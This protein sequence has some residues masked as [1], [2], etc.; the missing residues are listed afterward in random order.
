MGKIIKKIFNTKELAPALFL[1]NMFTQKKAATEVAQSIVGKNN[2][3]NKMVKEMIWNNCRYHF[4]FDEYFTYNLDMASAAKKKTFIPVFEQTKWVMSVNRMENKHIFANKQDTYEYFGE[5]FKRDL[6]YLKS[7]SN[8][9]KDL[10]FDFVKKNSRFI[11]KPNDLECGKGIRIIDLSKN[12]FQNMSDCFYDIIS[13]N[14][15]GVVLEEL[16]KQ[17]EKTAVFHPNSV[18][19]VRMITFRLDDR[20]EL[21]PPSFRMGVKGSVIDNASAG[22][23]AAAVDLKTGIIKRVVDKKGNDYI[24]HPDTKVQILG[25]KLPDW[26]DAIKLSK[27]LALVVPSNRY[28]GWDLAYT[29]KGWILVEGNSIANMMCQY[30]T[31]IGC[32]HII[33]DWFNELNIKCFK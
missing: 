7:D 12:S 18:N 19:T 1:V 32:K 33:E 31:G 27:E 17:S 2:V 3:T 30:T 6:I 8:E 9:E 26:E 10:F 29:D 16:I 25:A 4:S 13:S 5:Y 15:N 21:L 23:I 14:K 24:I 11:L 28:T 22:G 20:V